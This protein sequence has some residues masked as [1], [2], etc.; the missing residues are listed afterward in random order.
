MSSSVSK[1]GDLPLIPPSELMKRKT[2]NSSNVV[3]NKP[4]TN[5]PIYKED[6]FNKLGGGSGQ[7]VSELSQFGV[8]ALS[9]Y[10]YQGN[11]VGA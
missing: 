2:S 1:S 5:K 9:G 8:G 10:K 6:G 3:N 7:L 4:T 11:L